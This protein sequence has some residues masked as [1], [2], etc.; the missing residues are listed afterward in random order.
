MKKHT[1]TALITAALLLT[2]TIGFAQVDSSTIDFGDDSG[3]WANDGECDDPRFS[4]GGMHSILL[5][6]DAFKDATDC[7]TLFE[8]GEITFNSSANNEIIEPKQ[9]ESITHAGID[10]GTDSGIWANDDECDDPRFSGEGM[11]DVLLDSDIKAD[12]SDCKAA[13]I[14]GK[15]T[16]GES[17]R[18]PEKEAPLEFA[19]R[20][21]KSGDIDFGSDTS[22]WA[23]DDECDDP[24]FVGKGMSGVLLDEDKLA[25]ASDCKALFERG[26][27][28]LKSDNSPN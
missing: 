25:D 26:E 10:F 9:T 12:A 11:S 8:S 17:S 14:A 2:P 28:T 19:L 23:N 6:E 20:Q 24:R 22:E 3:D 4:G 5:D 15:I 27:I 18:S 16:L 13:F 7:K 1:K 21:F